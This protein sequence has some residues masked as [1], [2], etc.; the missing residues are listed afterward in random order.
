[1]AQTVDA[2][3]KI[4]QMLQVPVEALWEKIPGVTDQDV[5]Y[6]KSIKDS[7]D[8]LGGIVSEMQRQTNTPNPAALNGTSAA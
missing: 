5:T 1:M 6:W 4:A 3:G 8:L 2:L 7:T